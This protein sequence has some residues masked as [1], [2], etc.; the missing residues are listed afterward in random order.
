VIL[1]TPEK[2]YNSSWVALRNYLV[3]RSCEYS[4]RTHSY[5]NTSPT[6]LVIFYVAVLI[7]YLAW[8]CYQLY[9][10]SNYILETIFMMKELN[11]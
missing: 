11:Y 7:N 9:N 8:L 2:C 6:V 4:F 5:L 3:I 10:K 1:I